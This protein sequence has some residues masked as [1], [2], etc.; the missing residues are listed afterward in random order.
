ML[1]F[2]DVGLQ[3]RL[4]GGENKKKFKKTCTIQK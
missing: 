3:I 2:G 1:I 4:S